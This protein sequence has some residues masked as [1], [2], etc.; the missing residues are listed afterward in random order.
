MYIFTDLDK[1][2]VRTEDP[3]V[4]PLV[5]YR[6]QYQVASGEG[7]LKAWI[8]IWGMSIIGL[9]FLVCLP[10]LYL[11]LIHSHTK[12][13]FFIIY[14]ISF[15]VACLLEAA[16]GL[17]FLLFQ[18]PNV[19]FLANMSNE[20]ADTVEQIVGCCWKYKGLYFTFKGAA[21]CTF[22]KSCMDEFY[23][24]YFMPCF[25]TSVYKLFILSLSILILLYH[26]TFRWTT[27]KNR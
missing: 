24:D 21:A 23:G 17:K 25:I 26:W 1:A 27:V 3:N 18:V 13:T 5:L 12:M 4:H 19:H 15:S 10:A 8:P 9:Y 20:L 6:E 22:E 2:T 16:F 11:G 7:I 14:K